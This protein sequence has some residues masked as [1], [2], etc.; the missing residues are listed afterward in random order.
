M[1]TLLIALGIAIIFMS[2]IISSPSFI[3]EVNNLIDIITENSR[4][5]S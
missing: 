1:I 3:T 2:F 4:R 5:G